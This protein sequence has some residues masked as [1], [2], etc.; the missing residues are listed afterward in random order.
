MAEF[1]AMYDPAVL[2]VDVREPDEYA[3]GHVPGARL[4]PLGS[5]PERVGEIQDQTVYVICRSGQRSQV[6]ADL[7]A[8]LGR[9]AVSV[10]EGTMGW[11]ARGGPV[12]TGSAPR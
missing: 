10:E 12:V 7:L 9:T 8:A 1:Q 3:E 6:G 5:L 11:I 4:I 2:L